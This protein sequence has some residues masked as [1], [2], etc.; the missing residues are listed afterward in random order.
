[1]KFAIASMIVLAFAAVPAAAQSGTAA[2]QGR[3]AAQAG[4]QDTALAEGEVKKVDKGAGKVTIKHG[5][6][7]AL[8]MPAMTMVFRVKDPAMLEKVKV[9][10]NIRFKAEKVEGA[11]TVT[12]Y[13]AA[14]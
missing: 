8:D 7:T 11:F 13:Q 10:D 9:G 6:L 14:K 4:A 12:E 1:M 2:Q 5:P 3:A